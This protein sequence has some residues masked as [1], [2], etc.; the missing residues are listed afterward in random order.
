MT[1]QRQIGFWVATLAVLVLV[2]W[3]LSPIMLPFIAGLALAYFLDPVADA[4]ERLRLSRLAA[5]LVIL[6][7]SLLVLVLLLVLVV[8]P[9][10]SQVSK[11][12]ADFPSLLPAVAQHVQD[13][14]PQWLKDLRPQSQA[15]LQTGP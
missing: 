12:A 9:L 1:M 11:L 4:L 14:A 15:N 7:A 8:P 13:I 3:L 10:G 6:I 5:S 2:L